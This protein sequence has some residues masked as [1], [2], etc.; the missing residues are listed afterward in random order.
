MRNIVVIL[1]FFSI[2]LNASSEVYLCGG[3]FNEQL[4][5]KTF[6]RFGNKFIKKY[7]SKTSQW[8]ILKETDQFIILAETFRYPD[9]FISF[10]NKLS[11]EYM[12]NY[13]SLN[14]DTEKDPPKPLKG[15]CIIN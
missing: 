4:Q 12:E 9:I 3:K 7:N 6:E 15:K 11:F 13:L 14:L 8:K 1:I 5:I 2:S 10:I